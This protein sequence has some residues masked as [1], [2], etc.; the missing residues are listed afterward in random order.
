MLINN[1]SKRIFLMIFRE[2]HT[3]VLIRKPFVHI[4]V[5]K[6]SFTNTAF[7][8]DDNFQKDFLSA[9]HFLN[10]V[11]KIRQNTNQI[12]DIGFALIYVIVAVIA[13]VFVTG[14]SNLSVKFNYSTRI[15][16]IIYPLRQ[17]KRLRKKND[18]KMLQLCLTMLQ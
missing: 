4:L 7:T 11:K 1:S 18:K 12:I 2:C 15:L 16:Y 8:K 10:S 13:I 5:H 14:I 6:W 9:G 17:K 3:F